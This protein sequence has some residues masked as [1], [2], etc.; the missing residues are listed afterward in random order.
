MDKREESVVKM[1]RAV[2][3]VFDDNSELV[4]LTPKLPEGHKELNGLIVD[5][6]VYSQGQ[7]NKGTEFTDMK[8]EYRDA[9]ET[10]TL[11][12]CAA[13]VAYATA[14]T[15]ATVKLLINKYTLSDSDIKRLRDIQLYNKAIQVY[16]DAA[17][18]ASKLSPFAS[19]DDV[20]ALK[21]NADNFN[22]SLPNK[23]NQQGK[24]TVST[25]NLKEAIK[26]IET[27]CNET[28]DRLMAPWKFNKPNFYTAYKNARD[29]ISTGGKKGKGD[30]G[31]ND[32][33][34]GNT[35]S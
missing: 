8:E 24:S 14:S 32:T 15:D 19:A 35:P 9:T 20:T 11:K 25:K 28:L 6:E 22:N 17:P 29:I 3:K 34:G 21:T 18:Y 27:L 30:N 10:M 2:S 23:R 5:T 7:Q 13:L 16:D 33:K 26:A 12:I 1:A 4:N 31:T